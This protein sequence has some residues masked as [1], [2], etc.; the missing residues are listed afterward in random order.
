MK[1]QNPIIER[2]TNDTDARTEVVR[3]ANGSLLIYSG[4]PQ[5][6]DPSGADNGPWS[7]CRTTVTQDSQTGSTTIENTWAV[8]P[9]NQ[10][11]SLTYNYI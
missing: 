3:Q 7:I 11:A 2:L 6:K 1:N 5:I 8:G 4:K 9:W 10:R